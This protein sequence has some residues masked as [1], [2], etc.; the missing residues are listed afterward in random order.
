MP[1]QMNQWR[2]TLGD[3]SM[4]IFWSEGVIAAKNEFG[5]HFGVQRF[6]AHCLLAGNNDANSMTESLGAAIDRHTIT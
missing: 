2:G 4:L 1:A 6:L 5:E 3:S